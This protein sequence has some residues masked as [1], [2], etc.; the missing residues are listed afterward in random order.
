M[1]NAQGFMN[2]LAN[3]M[4]KESES[5]YLLSQYK[6]TRKFVLRCAVGNRIIII[7]IAIDNFCIVLFSGVAK[8]TA[9]I[10]NNRLIF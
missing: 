4:E 7:I 1:E 10:I 6:F 8:L 9:L 2:Q 3:N 5:E